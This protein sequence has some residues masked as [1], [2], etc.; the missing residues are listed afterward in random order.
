MPRPRFRAS[1]S[2]AAV[3]AALVALSGCSADETETAEQAQLLG[4]V[5]T[6]FGTIDVPAPED[7]LRVVA[8]GWSDAEMALALGVQPIAVFD[9]QSFDEENK[10][11]GP[12]ATELFGDVAPEIIERAGETLNYEQLEV[13]DPDVILNVRSASDEQEFERLNEIAPTIYAPVGTPAFATPWDVQ[14]E[15]VSA[16]LG[17]ADEGAAIVDETKAA[18]D[19]AAAAHPEFDGLTTVAGTKFADAYGAYLPG[20]GRFDILADLGFVNAP[21]IA[22]L[23]PSGFFANVS[24]EQVGVLD[25]DVPVIYPIGFTLEQ[26]KADPLLASLPA[27]Q[28][29]RAV[30]LDPDSELADAYA[31][32]ST[33]SFDV[34]LDGFVPLLADAA[35]KVGG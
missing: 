29:G 2:L 5:D 23:Q 12:W 8:L 6:M 3:A 4:S 14:M 15:T 26:T 30:F 13:L 19:A 18:I 16:A 25:A 10:G 34:V 21:A 1:V 17:L 32:A 22:D 20:D 33:L 7:E 24:A 28:E 27:V 9:W 35:A 11:V 31:T